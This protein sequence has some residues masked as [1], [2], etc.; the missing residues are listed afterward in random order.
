VILVDVLVHRARVA[1]NENPLHE[2]AIAK[3]AFARTD[4]LL[5]AMD[6]TQPDL[7]GLVVSLN[8]KR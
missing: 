6:G 1:R 7:E 8:G 3:R 2:I 5:V 4:G